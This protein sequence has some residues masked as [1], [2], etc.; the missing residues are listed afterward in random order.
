MYYNKI[1]INNFRGINSFAVEDL[2]DI[3]LFVGKNNS[4]KTTVLEALFILLGASNPELLLRINNFRDLP[5]TDD[6][7]LRFVFYNLDYS[8][9]VKIIAETTE[10]YGFRELR[11]KPSSIV[12]E[13]QKNHKT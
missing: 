11:I 12:V 13:D 8:N 2:K 6:N 3:N 5:M 9:N 1:E 7:D 10:K 4:S